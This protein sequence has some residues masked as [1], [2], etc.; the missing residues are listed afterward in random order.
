LNLSSNQITHIPNQIN[1]LT[2]LQSLDLSSNRLTEFPDDISSF[3][4]LSELWIDNNKLKQFSSQLPPNLVYLNFERNS[5]T[6]ISL[7]TFFSLTRLESL[8]LSWNQITILPTQ[9]GLLIALREIRF[10][11]SPLKFPP[12]VIIRFWKEFFEV[13]NDLYNEQTF[14]GNEFKEENEL[15]D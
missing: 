2:Q 12:K 10:F 5:I 13:H 3:L 14:N 15:I 8:N 9:I 1:K 4:H 11:N 6:S 7:T